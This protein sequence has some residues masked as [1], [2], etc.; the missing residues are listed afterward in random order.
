MDRWVDGWMGEWM[1]D[2]WIDR[3]MGSKTVSGNR[4]TD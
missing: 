3:W 4:C 1:D 2:E